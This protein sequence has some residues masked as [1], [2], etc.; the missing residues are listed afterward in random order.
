MSQPKRVALQPGYV[1]HPRPYRD[2]SLLVEALTPEHGRVGLVAKG[3]RAPRSR[4]RGLLQPFRPLLLSWSGSGDLATLVGAEANGPMMGLAGAGLLSG[5]YVNELL[6]RLLLRH[7]PHPALYQA[8][9]A[10]LTALQAAGQEEPALRIFEKR[11]LQELGYGLLLDREARS[12]QPIDAERRYRYRLDLGPLPEDE[13]DIAD[14][15]IHGSSLLALAREVLPA[16]PE[17]RQEAK[18]LMR[19][20]IARHLGGRPLKSRDLFRVHSRDEDHGTGG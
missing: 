13:G 6:V 7:D 5:F 18:R 12:G 15:A 16:D 11:L 8:Y 1:L 10:V 9:E 3:V 17:R 14:P 20:A 19:A 2:T 4:M